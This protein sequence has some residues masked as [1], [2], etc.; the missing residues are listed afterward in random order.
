MSLPS[1]SKDKITILRPSVR[2]ERGTQ[3]YDYSNPTRIDINGCEVQPLN[4]VL[5]QQERFAVDT[6]YSVFCPPDVEIYFYD[7][8][9]YVGDTYIINGKPFL[10]KSPSG[11]VSHVKFNMEVW[12]G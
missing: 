7:R 1:F 9:E 3:F 12:S 8:I 4:T 6:T 10:V 5:N 2:E 11:A